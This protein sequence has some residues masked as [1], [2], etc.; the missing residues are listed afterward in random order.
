MNLSH[1]VTYFDIHGCYSTMKNNH[2]V[3]SAFSKSFSNI[4]CCSV[5]FQNVQ[6]EF[7]VNAKALKTG[8][9]A[10]VSKVKGRGLRF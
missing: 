8:A 2:F 10:A 1:T 9:G 7:K 6:L 3:L 4:H 5:A